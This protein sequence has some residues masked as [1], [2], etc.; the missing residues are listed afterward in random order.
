M[1]RSEQWR[2]RATE[3]WLVIS[4]LA[5]RGLHRLLRDRVADVVATDDAGAGIGRE[6]VTGKYPEPRE[7]ASGVGVRLDTQLAAFGHA[8]AAPVDE[9]SASQPRRPAHGAQQGRRLGRAQDRGKTRPALALAVVVRS[10]TSSPY[11]RSVVQQASAG[12]QNQAL[13]ALLDCQPQRGEVHLVHLDPT[14]GSKIRKTRPCVIVSP[15]ELNLHLRT[16][17][18]APMTT[19]GQA[20][21]VADPVPVST[22]CGIRRA[23]SAAHSRPGPPGQ[24]AWANSCLQPSRPY[25]EALQEMFTE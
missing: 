2:G 23:G 20:I 11:A 17:V 4:R 5:R 13:C 7:L 12:A 14:L 16:A 10:P 25:V 24:A 15:D 18:V 21:P 9:V 6:R 1:A 22:A 19:G 3:D 8:Q